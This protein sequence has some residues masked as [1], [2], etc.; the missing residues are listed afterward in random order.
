MANMILWILVLGVLVGG[1][2]ALFIV[3]SRAA[4]AREEDERPLAGA[5]GGSHAAR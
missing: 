4:K 3:G 1:A 2:V 5:P